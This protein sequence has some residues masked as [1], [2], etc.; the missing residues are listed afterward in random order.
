MKLAIYHL[1]GEYKCGA[2]LFRI[3][4]KNT[5]QCE[6][7]GHEDDNS[8]HVILECGILLDNSEHEEL[9][10][11]VLTLLSEDKCVSVESIKERYQGNKSLFA[12]FL[13]N[14]LS[15]RNPPE[16]KVSPRS[17][18]CIKIIL[19]AQE[20]VLEAH[21]ARSKAKRILEVGGRYGSKPTKNGGRGSH[22]RRRGHHLHPQGKTVR[23][24]KITRYFKSNSSKIS[25]SERDHSSFQKKPGDED[26][27]KGRRP[28]EWLSI[29]TDSDQI[30]YEY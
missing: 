5:P 12:Q 1:I 18:N 22:H 28:P 16:L 7:C 20:V 29:S 26:L 9:V 23:L 25:K 19:A 15:H 3:K 24:N 8:E 21:N 27:E 11:E 10:A 30:F 6:Y 14:P 17:K 4:L 13:L 2:N